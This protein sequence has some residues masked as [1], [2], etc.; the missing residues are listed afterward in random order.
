MATLYV[1]TLEPQSG[2]ALTIGEAGQNTVLAGND[3]RANVLQ[4]A[5]GNAI[6]T[7]NGSGTLSGVNSDIGSAMVLLQTQ[8]PTGVTNISFSSPGFTSTYKE[9]IFKFYNVAP[10]TDGAEFL[11]QVSDDGGSTYAMIMLSATAETYNGESAAGAFV[12]N[13]SGDLPTGGGGAGQTNYQWLAQN[14]GNDADQSLNG[15][16]HIGM[17]AATDRFKP[18][19]A[20]IVG[21]EMSQYAINSVFGG[22]VYETAAFTAIDFKYSTGNIAAGKIK[23]FGLK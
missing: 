19:W 14:M 1:D 9:Y 5:G 7:S 21:A 17:P 11:F 22:I 6:F 8:T 15:T 13:S 2:T 4:D 16:L 20:R 10:A 23:M 18:W 12:Y 3:L